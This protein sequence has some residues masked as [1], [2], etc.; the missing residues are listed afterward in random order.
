MIHRMKQHCWK[1]I[2]DTRVKFSL[3]L[4]ICFKHSAAVNITQNEIKGQLLYG[5]GFPLKGPCLKQCYRVIESHFDLKRN[6]LLHF[7]FIYLLTK[8]VQ[9][10]WR[11]LIHFCSRRLTKTLVKTEEIVRSKHSVR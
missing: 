6:N 2:K 11:I 4:S 3:F 7:P 9:T 10:H 1:V 8:N 5:K